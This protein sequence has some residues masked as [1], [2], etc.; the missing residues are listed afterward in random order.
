MASIKD[1]AKKAGVSVTTV[2]RTFNNRG[3]IS[4]ATRK[5]INQACIDLD[6]R[7]NELARS[8]FK[9]KSNI[10]GVLIPQLNNEFF[11]V[12]S[13]KIENKLYY[14]GYKTMLC[15]TNGDIEKE[16]SYFNMFKSQMVDGVI[17]GSY[18]LED[19]FKYSKYEMPLIAFDR[20]LEGN[21]PCVGSDH[22][23]IGQLGTEK[24]IN[25]G[26]KKLVHL[27]GVRTIAGPTHKKTLA[28]EKICEQNNLEY[29]IVEK[30]RNL[31]VD[32][33][34]FLESMREV[35]KLLPD[36]DGIFLSDNDAAFFLQYAH[37]NNIKVP[38]D[39]QVVGYD[40]IPLCEFTYPQITTI[41][42]DFDKVS[43]TLVN[44]LIA[45]I[46]KEEL[47]NTQNK[48]ELID[49]SLINR[50]STK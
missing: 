37:E 18:L 30:S 15:F 6:Y 47:D 50:T 10:I 33:V 20:Y 4:E 48:L 16:K 46:N 14:K 26:C 49:V 11:S 41:A 32:K 35:E 12:L 24:L 5:K 40:N 31:L 21:I 23:K 43:E 7:P 29:L 44:S 2:S 39:V 22:Y 34:A 45:L 3:Y 1:V 8:L 13:Q 36:F 27:C 38:E 25:G 42:Q 9:K 17:I 28:F 19:T